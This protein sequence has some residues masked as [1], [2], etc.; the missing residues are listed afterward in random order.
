LAKTQGWR[1]EKK[2]KQHLPTIYRRS[3]QEERSEKLRYFVVGTLDPREV[4]VQ[5]AISLH[6]DV[7]IIDSHSKHGLLDIALGGTA[8]HIS[9]QARCLVVLVA[10]KS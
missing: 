1:V 9:R 4:I 5:V 6:T 7:L 10:L 8:Q 2:S 3:G